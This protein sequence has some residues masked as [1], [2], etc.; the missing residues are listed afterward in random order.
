[1]SS[2]YKVYDHQIPHLVT[3]TVVGW[4]DALS[5]EWYKEE[6]CKSIL[7]CINERGLLLNAWVIMNN[8]IHLIVQTAPGIL[9]SDVMRDFKKYTSRKIIDAVKNNPQESRKEW[10]LNMFAFRGK[11][12]NSNEEYQFWQQDY[13]PIALDN[14]EKLLQRLA[15]LHNNP[16]KAGIVWEPQHYK[17]SS[18]IDYYENKAGLLPIK[19]LII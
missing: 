2:R 18:A 7:Y 3:S 10:M 19:R 6:I 12:N 8:H 15:Y 9:I 14:E 13:H 4:I 5:R 16:V 17:Y 1:M 11:N